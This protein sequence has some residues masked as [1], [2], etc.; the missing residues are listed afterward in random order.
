MFACIRGAATLA[1]GLGLA[2][3][4]ATGLVNDAQAQTRYAVATGSPTSGY[5]RLFSPAAEYI[6]R[7]SE[8]IRLTP[9]STD[10][11]TENCRR[12]GGGDIKFGMCTT[13]DLP[14]A[15]NGREPFPEALRDIR[16]AGPDLGAIV[17]HFMVRKDSGVNSFADLAGKAFGCGA[18][19]SSATQI[20]KDVLTQ[21]GLIDKVDVVE[22]PFDQLGDMVSNRDIVGMSRGMIGL[23]AG[24]AQELNTRVPLRVLDVSVITDDAAK[25]KEM[26]SVSKMTIPAGTYDWQ[27]EPIN[28]I[29]VGSYFIVNKNVPDDDVYEFVRLVNSQ[30]MVDHMQTAFKAHGFYPRNKD[31]LSGLLVPLHPGAERFWKSTG[32]SIPAP[33]LGD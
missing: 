17:M 8:K 4:G 23:P 1:V 31:P 32:V 3:G 18:P 29:W 16:T 28:T 25:L 26:P 12:V 22:L 33:A 14:N 30:G 19:G 15:W 9:L 27:P 5:Y 6:N 10:G 13:L 21:L 20:C 11:S 2:L 24:F 7:N